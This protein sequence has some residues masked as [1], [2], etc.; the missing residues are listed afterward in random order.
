MKGKTKL[1]KIQHHIKISCGFLT[2][3][4][5]APSRYILEQF[6]WLNKSSGT[7]FNLQGLA[8][9]HPLQVPDWAALELMGI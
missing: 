4:F 7:N 3:A 2:L 6:G 9:E 8:S 1:Q 5:C